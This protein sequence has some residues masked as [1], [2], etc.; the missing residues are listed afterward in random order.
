M[1]N[2][3]ENGYWEG[4]D[5]TNMHYFDKTLCLYLL[6]FFKSNFNPTVVDLGCGLGS[7]VTNL[8]KKG[9]TIDGFDGNPDTPK[10][11]EFCKVLDLSKSIIFENPYD[12]V[13]CLEVGEH[14]PEQFEDIL[15]NNLHNNNKKGIILSWAVEGQAGDGHVNCRNN[16]YIKSKFLKLNY[17]NDITLENEMRNV[18]S[19][20]WFKNTIMVFRK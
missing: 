8:R 9:I 6:K 11:N 7:Y 3:S 14:L 12:W 4:D 16:D 2:I 13:M 18:T 19:L 5:V 20:D 17:T 15:I 10:L 1:V